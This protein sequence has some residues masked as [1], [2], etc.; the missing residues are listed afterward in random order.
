MVNLKDFIKK[1]AISIGFDL[2]GFCKARNF[3]EFEKYYNQKIDAEYIADVGNIRNIK[4][5]LNCL[6]IM[7]DAKTI[8]STAISYNKKID[9]PQ[10][11]E[12]KGII[13]HHVF[14]TDYHTIMTE[15]M[16]ELAE[17]IKGKV[18]FD[19]KYKCF[20]DTGILDDRIAAYC[21]G[22]GFWGKNN[23]IINEKLGSYIFLGSILTNL[24]IEPDETK[25]S[26]CID[27]TACINACPTGALK[28]AHICNAKICISNLN[29][30]KS[31]SENEKKLIGRNIFGCNVC[32]EV[33]GFNKNAQIC[34][35][36]FFS[37]KAEDVYVDCD[38]IINMDKDTF[39]LK[40]KNTAMYWRGYEIIK[41]NA[42]IAKNNI[43]VITDK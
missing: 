2:I 29:Q 21:A 31:L 28:G 20:C 24:E 37:A 7:P 5:R 15:K 33:C 36:R 14:N 16:T 30:K 23:F 3:S 8:I 27:C 22:I 39:D 43:E 35:N 18:K 40:Y 9:K 6:D 38:D 41:R 1:S 10:D 32:Q 26:L 17:K 11:E 13:S 12:K 42:A 25:E 4:K 34:H 19:F